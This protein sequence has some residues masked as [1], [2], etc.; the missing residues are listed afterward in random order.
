[1]NSRELD[2][3][4]SSG[5]TMNVSPVAPMPDSSHRPSIVMSLL[6]L[7]IGNCSA[8]TPSTRPCG[9]TGETNQAVGSLA[10]W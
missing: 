2:R 9:P 6:I 8:S 7:E 10:G 5:P 3:I 1:M 4:R